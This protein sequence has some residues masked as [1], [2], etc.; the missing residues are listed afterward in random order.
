[1]ITL[2][3]VGHDCLVLSK[4]SCVF[5]QEALT[6]LLDHIRTCEGED[7][8]A[9]K[10]TCSSLV[11]RLA[12]LCPDPEKATQQLTKLLQTKDRK[13]FALMEELFDLRPIQ[14]VKTHSHVFVVMPIPLVLFHFLG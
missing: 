10:D 4:V 1:M 3:D 13:V 7:G 8:S 9:F 11:K 12:R 6:S 2:V 14:E 5:L